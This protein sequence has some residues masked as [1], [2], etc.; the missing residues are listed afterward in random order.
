M[1]VLPNYPGM[2]IEKIRYVTVVN[3]KV[4]VAETAWLGGTRA[5]VL[6][7]FVRWHI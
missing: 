6:V 7:A 3:T 5:Y 4:H 1:L 2:L